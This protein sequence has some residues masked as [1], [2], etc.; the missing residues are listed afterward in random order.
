[1][2]SCLDS[3]DFLGKQKVKSVKILEHLPY[4]PQSEK[5]CLQRFA[6]NTDA[7]QPAHLRSLISTFFGLLESIVS[8]LA[9]S[10]IFQ[11]VSVAAETGLNL[12]L[13]ETPKTG[14]LATVPIY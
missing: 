5:T 10:K 3:Q 12:T 8:R 9:T 13:L 1:M 7:D 6:K 11:L 2:N 14:F 4:G